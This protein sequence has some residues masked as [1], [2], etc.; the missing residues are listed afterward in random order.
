MRNQLYMVLVLFLMIVSSCKKAE[1]QSSNADAENLSKSPPAKQTQSTFGPL[2]GATFYSAAS[3]GGTAVLLNAGTYT[4]AQLAAKGIAD[5]TASSIKVPFGVKVT[6][7]QDDNLTGTSWTFTSDETNFTT[8]TP[9]ANDQMSSCKVE[10]YATCYQNTNYGGTASQPLT[11]GSYTLAQ[12]N[13]KGILNDW[14]NSIKVPRGLIV[15]LFADDNFQGKACTFSGNDA[16]MS[17][18]PYNDIAG[19]VSSCKVIAAPG[20]IAI[21]PSTK[22][23]YTLTMADE[24]SG[25]SLD[26]TKWSPYYFRG[27]TSTDAE[28]AAVYTVSGGSLNL[29]IL[30]NSTH[31]NSGIQSVEDY[32][33]HFLGG[34]AIPRKILFAQ[35]YGYF[36]ARI[37]TQHGSG[38]CSSYWMIGAQDGGTIESAEADIIEQPG[39]YGD[40]GYPTHYTDHTLGGGGVTEAAVYNYTLPNLTD[41]YNVYALEWTPTVMNYYFNNVLYWTTP[42]RT[43]Y[44]MGVVFSLYNASSGF[45]G[46]LDPSIPYPKV[47]QV[48]YFRAYSKN[49]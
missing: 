46:T 28:A 21:N 25:T 7:Y 32:Q 23:G 42:N 47:M 20:E 31:S 29:K 36:E 24:F 38:S 10:L 39:S 48:D 27:R 3:Y 41:S 45:F 34:R 22:P 18:V 13:A 26:T 4:K 14:V 43:D 19:L 40:Y 49:P 30:Q 44:R 33:M 17:Y 1:Q 15:I 8:L 35:K 5:N 12:L 2:P 6:M 16:T 9:Y 11:V 37:K